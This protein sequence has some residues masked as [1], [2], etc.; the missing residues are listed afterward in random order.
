M[1]GDF[2]D[3]PFQP[4]HAFKVTTAK[5]NTKKKAKRDMNK[6]QLSKAKADHKAE[7]A[8][9]KA[10]IKA[11]KQDIKRHNLLLKQAKI[12]YKLTQMKAA[13]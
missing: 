9:I 2:I 13:K 5:A 4:S 11:K 8:K 3:I 7:I 1:G 12:T 10:D 6:D